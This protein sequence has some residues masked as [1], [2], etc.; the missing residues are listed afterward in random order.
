MAADI[1]PPSLLRYLAGAAV[2]AAGL[3]PV[4]LRLLRGWRS[5]GKTRV[6]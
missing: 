3:L 1:A 4:A 2:L 5:T 6:Q